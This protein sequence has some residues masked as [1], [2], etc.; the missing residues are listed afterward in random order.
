[1]FGVVNIG[2]KDVEMLANAATPYRFNQVFKDDFLQRATSGNEAAQVDL[3]IKVGFIM[4]KQAE[5]KTD[6][7]KLNVESFYKWLEDFEP[8]AMTEAVTE[9]AN[10]YSGNTVNQATPK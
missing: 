9:I 2:G 10:I 5:K 8:T 3:F 1:M 7:S 4:A 6:I